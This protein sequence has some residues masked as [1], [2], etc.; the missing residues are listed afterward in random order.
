MRYQSGL[1]GDSLLRCQHMVCL[2]VLL[3]KFFDD[4]CGDLV[5][6]VRGRPSLIVKPLRLDCGA[7]G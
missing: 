3:G 2:V 6:V 4:H 1:W 7:S 5:D